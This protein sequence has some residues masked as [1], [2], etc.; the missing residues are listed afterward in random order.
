MVSLWVVPPQAPGNALARHV[1]TVIHLSMQRLAGGTEAE[2][3]ALQL[4]SYRNWWRHQ[5]LALQVGAA[6][7]PAALLAIENSLNTVL[8]DERGRWL[9]SPLRE[10]SS[11]EYRLSSLAEDG[12]LVEHVIDRTYVEDKVRWVVDYKSSVPDSGES[13]E[14]FLRRAAQRRQAK[15]AQQSQ[16]APRRQPPQY[17]DRR[18]ERS[19]QPREADE[20][21]AA[22]VVEDDPNS[23]SARLRR[24]EE[25][26]QAAAKAEAEAAKKL[27]KAG[28]KRGRSKSSGV[29]LALSGNPTQNL[30][31]M[32]R[33]SG[34]IRQAILLREILDRPEHRW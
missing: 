4:S 8:A 30:I 13:L 2:L 1:G 33:H 23:F 9:L 29:A 20:V 27:A 24:L 31:R 18:T 16:P 12:R 26:K 15:S 14:D 32:L 10:Q 7:I 3:T 28:V 22:E 25:A 19:V 11:C 17:S 21:L 5:L 6:D 34:G